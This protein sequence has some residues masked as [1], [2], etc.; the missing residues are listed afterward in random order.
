MQKE[1]A[2]A[3]PDIGVLLIV[4]HDALSYVGMVSGIA[5]IVGPAK[6]AGVTVPTDLTSSLLSISDIASLGVVLVIT[7]PSVCTGLIGT[8]AT[9]SHTRFRIV[10]G[11]TLSYRT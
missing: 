6:D 8:C 7:C 10:T 1:T 3:R 9:Y 5:V 11:R 2:Y 4:I